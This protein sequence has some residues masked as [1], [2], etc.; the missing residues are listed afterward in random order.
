VAVTDDRP[1]LLMLRALGLGD[2]LTAVP[3]LH[4]LADCF[5]GYRRVLATPQALAPLALAARLAD[6]VV[7]AAPLQRLDGVVSRPSV[8]VNLHGRGPESHHVVLATRPDHVIAFRHRKVEGVRGPFWRAG[9][10]EVARWCRLLVESGI[11]ADP[12]HLG[13]DLPPRPVPVEVVGASIVHPGAQSEARR[14]PAER[15]ARVAASERSKGRRVIVTGDA[16]ERPL[17]MTVARLAGL[18][19]DAVWAGRTDVLTLATLVER[20]GRVVCGDTGIAHLATALGTPSV[21]LFGPTPPSEWGPPADRPWHRVLWNG[22]RG[23]P[24]ASMPDPGLLAIT[25]DEV[26]T[27]LAELPPSPMLVDA[28]GR[29][30][31]AA[32]RRCGATCDAR[33]DPFWVAPNGPHDPFAPDEAH[34]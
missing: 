31:R 3:A 1:T 21:V 29:A 10:H 7:P 11:D 9:E 24:H 34:W 13:I 6:D 2:L 16:S 22:S 28:G 18:R 12:D 17:A 14:W 15:W 20:A 33:W 8:A 19:P 25:A 27:A 5:P 26:I 4:A 23:D 32:R 30:M